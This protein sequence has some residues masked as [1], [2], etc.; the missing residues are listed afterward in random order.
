MIPHPFFHGSLINKSQAW[1]LAFKKQTV[2]LQRTQKP[3]PEFNT[4][5]CSHAYI[6]GRGNGT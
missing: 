4:S 6:S 3:L 5:S 1:G 2:I